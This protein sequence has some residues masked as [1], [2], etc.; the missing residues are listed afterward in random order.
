[1]KTNICT[2]PIDCSCS[3]H[4]EVR[5]LASILANDTST[6]SSPDIPSSDAD[7]DGD[8]DTT[9]ESPAAANDAN[10][11]HTEE[12]PFTAPFTSF[13]QYNFC[14]SQEIPETDLVKFFSSDAEIY[15]DNKFLRTKNNCA[16][17]TCSSPDLADCEDLGI[18]WDTPPGS[19]ESLSPLFEGDQ[20][21]FGFSDRIW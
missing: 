13:L 20:E 10:Q 12:S 6:T 19:F 9:T 17:A 5:A 1:L 11:E 16:F 21:D 15:V 2:P 4:P 18:D 14:E 3:A 7:F 8:V